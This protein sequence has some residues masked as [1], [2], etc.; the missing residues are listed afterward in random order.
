ME[1]FRFV[2][3]RP[4]R[5]VPRPL[6]LSDETD[7]GKWLKRVW[8]TTPHAERLNPKDIKSKFEK[9]HG[10]GPVN[11][12]VPAEFPKFLQAVEAKKTDQ[13][14]GIAWFTDTITE[15]F[16]VT[17]PTLLADPKFLAVYALVSDSL[18]AAK[19]EGRQ[20]SLHFRDLANY[21]R[22]L[23]LIKL[24]AAKYPALETR[25]YVGEVLASP[26]GPPESWVAFA[27]AKPPAN[28]K[29]A[30]TQAANS[31]KQK[32]T[33]AK[34]LADLLE[35]AL[36]DLRF[37]TMADYQL[38]RP[39]PPTPPAQLPP[40][41]HMALTGDF[42]TR[43]PRLAAGAKGLGIDLAT[44]AAP[45]VYDM[46]VSAAR[47]ATAE[48]RQ[49]DPVDAR[50]V[51]VGSQWLQAEELRVETSGQ[52]QQ[53]QQQL[54]DTVRAARPVGIADLLV[55]KQKLKKYHLGEIAHIENILQGETRH[56]EHKRTDR[57]EI[58]TTVEV[59]TTKE[60]ERDLQ[61]TDKA[62]LKQEAEHIIKSDNSVQAGV[63]LSASY[64]PVSLST[65]LSS[66]SSN[67]VQD[68]QRQATTFSKEVVARAVSRTT[69]RTLTRRTEK[70]LFEI[71][72]TNQ[73]GFSSESKNVSGIYRWVN[74]VYEA[75]V[76]N[77]GRR[78]LYEIVV[79]EPAA[80]FKESLSGAKA[81]GATLVKPRPIDFTPGQLTD[82]NW[83]DYAAR[84]ELGTA[85]APPRQYV[86]AVKV[87]SKTGLGA[88]TGTSDAADIDIPEGYKALSAR[89]R[90]SGVLYVGMNANVDVVVGTT[91]TRFLQQ[92]YTEYVILDDEVGKIGTGFTSLNYSAFTISIEVT[93]D[94]TERALHEWQTKFFGE[95]VTAYNSMLSRFEREMDRQKEAEE[96]RPYGR[97]P[98]ADERIVRGE[99]RKNALVLIRRDNFNGFAAIQDD[100]QS[101][102][103]TADIIQADKIARAVLFFEQAFE[104]EQLTYRFYEY[105]WGR[106]ERW[107][108]DL[109]L[110]DKNDQFRAFLSAGSAR[111]VLPVRPG[112]EKL[113]ANYFETGVIA[114]D[115][116]VPDVTSPE[117]LPILTEIKDELSAPGTEKAYGP[118]WEVTVPTTLVMLQGADGQLP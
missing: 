87:Y 9:A 106:K 61:S 5:E 72:E 50:L 88:N 66:S 16:G 45:E 80:F 76:Y 82:G 7:F 75:Q 47:D 69:E 99:L 101:G 108:K 57:Q 103:P 116:D 114:N 118:A 68:A 35:G 81:E 113:V 21:Y 4:A 86:T 8:T 38:Q 23:H 15:I 90:Q 6:A 22:A 110:D 117:Y 109:L 64:G 60:E 89:I 78:M 97:N 63:S 33:D 98:L 53:Q 12:N 107:K 85:T 18:L 73:H 62:E 14:I 49:V 43:H 111:L 46:L 30:A 115:D 79:P 24:T 102:G 52:Q 31:K 42:V 95:L 13:Q 41:T 20:P 29:Q 3:A 93:C 26:L 11:I 70:K 59:E 25:Q 28:A 92:T 104:W 51:R 65:N 94:R 37:A 39:P 112:F 67:S 55:V 19:L 2:Q 83:I 44:T 71:V 91:L 58:D 32:A 1:I 10:K 56:R 96:M 17:P 77:Y 40:Y 105:F 36:A 27:D 84:Y 48:L 34:S 100:P 74:K 54:S